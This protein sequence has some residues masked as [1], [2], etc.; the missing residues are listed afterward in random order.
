MIYTRVSADQR[1]EGRSVKS[2]EQECREVCQRN[3]WPVLKVVTDNDLSASRYATKERPGFKELEKLLR[4]GMVLVAWEASRLSRDMATFV[5]LRDLCLARG[6][7]LCYSG[8]IVD[9]EDVKLLIDGAMAEQEARRISERVR[10]GKDSAAAEGRPLRLPYGYMREMT[11]DG[12]TRWVPHPEQAPI[13]REITK[14]VLD[15]ESLWSIARDLKAREVPP[16]ATQRNAAGEWRPQR[17]RVM[18][19]SPSYAGLRVHRGEVIGEGQWEPLISRETHTR[20]VGILSDPSRRSTERGP[21]PRHL[22]TGIARCGKCGSPMRF[23]GNPPSSRAR[24]PRYLCE[25][26]SCVGRRQDLVDLLVVETVLA[27]LERDDSAALFSARHNDDQLAQAI[28]HAQELKDRLAGFEAAAA[29]GEITPKGFAGIEAR[30]RPQIED[31]EAKVQQL[32]AVDNPVLASLA[33]PDVRERWECLSIRD[34][35]AVVRS[36]VEV[37]VHPIKHGT[38]QRFDPRDIEISWKTDLL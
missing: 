26:K 24:A 17:M 8:Q 14:R 27:R 38:T 29:A 30:L 11:V 7:K 36:L 10:R 35:R 9:L 2:Q 4:K 32:V 21:E 1:G 18:L 23:V 22:L 15:G 19:M 5:A 33:G 12:T 34:R 6:V 28:S 3:R 16:P 20:L 31:A 13:V 37:T 25:A